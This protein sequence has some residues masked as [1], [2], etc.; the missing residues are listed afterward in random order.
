MKFQKNHNTNSLKNFKP[1]MT[2]AKY[3]SE[4]LIRIIS[5]STQRNYNAILDT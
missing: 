2:T 1:F 5:K 3:G 4:I